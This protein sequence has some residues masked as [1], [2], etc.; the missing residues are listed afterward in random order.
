MARDK[1]PQFDRNH[2]GCLHDR[3]AADSW[4]GRGCDE[5][6]WYPEGTFNGKR[7]I[8]LTPE[9]VSEYMEGYNENENDGCARK[10]YG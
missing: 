9:E 6:H 3:G 10:D 1:G 4:Y 8:D 2:H 5:P 7:V